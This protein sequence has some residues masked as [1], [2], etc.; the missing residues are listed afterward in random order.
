[1]IIIYPFCFVLILL[2]CKYVGEGSCLEE[3][4]HSKEGKMGHQI[5]NSFKLF[6]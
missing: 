3:N 6:S 4:T 5:N 2:I 1:M